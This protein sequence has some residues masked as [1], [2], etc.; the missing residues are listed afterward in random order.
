MWAQDIRGSIVYAK[1]IQ[2]VTILTY[3]ESS[4]IVSVLE[5][6]RSQWASGNFELK[7]GDEDVHTANERPLAE[8]NGDRPA[9]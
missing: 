3:D 7:T 2:R 6:V 9:G 1:S 8:P 5:D 4:A